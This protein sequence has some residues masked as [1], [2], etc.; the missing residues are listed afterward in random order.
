MLC[1]KEFFL[2]RIPQAITNTE[3]E[4]LRDPHHE[5]KQQNW[6]IPSTNILPFLLLID[7][8]HAHPG[9][10]KPLNGTIMHTPASLYKLSIN[11]LHKRRV[12]FGPL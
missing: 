2:G 7:L 11:F 8:F 4:M 12:D 1:L 5:E 6:P 9:M 10:K 3:N